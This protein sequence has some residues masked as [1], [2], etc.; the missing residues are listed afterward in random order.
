VADVFNLLIKIGPVVLLLG[1]IASIAL[2]MFGFAR[3]G[4]NKARWLRAPELQRQP[5]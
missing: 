2:A 1:L 5:S 4:D 3:Q